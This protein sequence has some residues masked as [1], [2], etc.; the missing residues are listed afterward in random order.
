MNISLTK[1]KMKKAGKSIV[2]EDEINR[3][4]FTVLRVVANAR[5]CCVYN[6]AAFSTPEVQNEHK[7]EK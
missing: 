1:I 5:Q 3:E 4:Q 6:S 2:T 7:K